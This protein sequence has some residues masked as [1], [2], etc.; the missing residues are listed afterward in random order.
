M[1]MI[2]TILILIFL[3][4][5]SWLQPKYSSGLEGKSLPGI[6]LM[7]KDSL[8]TFNTKLITSGQP[9]V[10]FLYHASC[11]YCNAQTVDIIKNI[12][13]FKGMSIYFISTDPYA[14]IRQYSDYY[15]LDKHSNIIM[16]RDSASQILDYFKAPGEPYLAFYDSNRKLKQ[17]LL[18]KNDF[19]IIQAI[20]KDLTIQS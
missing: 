13:A 3:S 15:K 8:T 12:S 11:P 2:N 17:V 20:I 9:F 4:S 14:L 18:G 5:C 6:N 16:A 19:K 7:S 1:K 10:L